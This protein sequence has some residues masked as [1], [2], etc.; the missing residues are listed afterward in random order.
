MIVGPAV[1]PSGLR[2]YGSAM[3]L[4]ELKQAVLA[5]SPHDLAELASF[6]REEDAKAWDEQIDK[7]FSQEGRLQCISEEV[8]NDLRFGK[9]GDLPS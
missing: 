2:V 3:G 1:P 8:R 5:L 7:D 4:A 9:V 6:I